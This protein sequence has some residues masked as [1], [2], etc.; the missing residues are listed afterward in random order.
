M[1]DGGAAALPPPAAGSAGVL[2]DGDHAFTAT[3]TAPVEGGAR[4]PASEPPLTATIDSTPGGVGAFVTTDWIA[5]TWDANP[6]SELRY[7][8]Y[9][10]TPEAPEPVRITAAPLGGTRYEDA[11]LPSGTYI[12][13]VRAVNAHG[14]ES[15]FSAPVEAVYDGSPPELLST[16][17]AEGATDVA[18]DA[19]IVLTFSEEIAVPTRNYGD[20]LFLV[21][22]ARARVVA[23]TATWEGV[24]ATITPAQALDHEAVYELCVATRLTDLAGHPLV[25][26]SPSHMQFR[27]APLDAWNGPA[28]PLWVTFDGEG[29]PGYPFPSSVWS[30]GFT[31][32]LDPATVNND[33]VGLESSD[34]AAVPPVLVEL[35]AN[36]LS[37]RIT[38]L[39]PLDP[40]NWWGLRLKAAIRDRAGNPISWWQDPHP[41]DVVYGFFGVYADQTPP[42]VTAAAPGHG[43]EGVRLGRPIRLT[44]WEQID[45]TTVT[46]E[47]VRVLHDDVVLEVTRELDP[48]GRVLTLRPAPAAP[49]AP[50]W[51]VS[52]A[53][54]VAVSSDICDRAGKGLDQEP[55]TYDPQPF[56]LSF[57]TGAATDEGPFVVGYAPARG[58]TQVLP[59]D[60]PKLLFSEPL[61]AASLADGGLEISAA[62]APVA[63]GWTASAERDLL[64]FTPAA[65]LPYGAAVEVAVRPLGGPR[66]DAGL[67][68]NQTAQRAPAAPFVA[69]W[70]VVSEAD[71]GPAVTW[72]EP[73]G[74]WTNNPLPLFRVGVDVVGAD[75]RDCVLVATLDG[76]AIE[77][78]SLPSSAP[79]VV[80]FYLPYYL[81]PGTPRT[82]RV[83]VTDPAGRSR[84]VERTLGLDWEAPVI[85][86]QTPDGAAG[87]ILP[88][89]GLRIEFADPHSGVETVLFS[90]DGA[91]AVPATTLGAGEATYAPAEPWLPGWHTV[92]AEVR[93]RAGNQNFAYWYPL[94]VDGAGPEISAL[95]PA[96]GA[97]L[98]QVLWIAATFWD[99]TQLTPGSGVLE[100]DGVD[101]THAPEA[102]PSDYW[103]YYLPPVLDA[104]PHVVRARVRDVLG[105]E[106]LQEWS[107]VY[108]PT[109]PTATLVTPAPGSTV[110]EVRPTLEIQLSD[111]LVGS[112]IDPN[113]VSVVVSGWENGFTQTG[114]TL[115]VTP[116]ADLPSGDVPIAV[117]FADLAGNPGFATWSIHVDPQGSG[118]LP[119]PDLAIVAPDEGAV[120]RTPEPVL[121]VHFTATVDAVDRASLVVTLDPFGGSPVDLSAEAV[122]TATGV[123]VAI[124]SAHALALGE[125]AVRVDLADTAGRVS[126]AYRAFTVDDRGPVLSIAYP[127][128]GA[129][130]TTARPSLRIDFAANGTPIDRASLRVKLEPLTVGAIDISALA[131]DLP[132]VG[133]AGGGVAIPL[134]EELALA[135][136]SHELSAELTDTAGR[137]SVAFVRFRVDVAEPV[138]QVIAGGL[139]G[140]E[141]NPAG[142][143]RVVLSDPGSGLANATFTAILNK[144]TPE[145]RDVT[146]LALW[147]PQQGEMRL[148]FA[149]AGNA[150]PEGR[151]TLTVTVEDQAGHTAVAAPSFVVDLTP[152]V[153]T[154]VTPVAN[155]VVGSLAPRIEVTYTDE[156]S[157]VIPATARLWINDA[158]LLAGVSADL[159]RIAYQ[160]ID[161]N[162]T[163]CHEGLNTLRATVSDA[164]GHAA[165]LLSE[166]A[167][168]VAFEPLDPDA[169]AGPENPLIRLMAVGG[170][171]QSGLN[172]SAAGQHLL[173]KAADRSGRPL[174]GIPIT[175]QLEGEGVLFPAPGRTTVTDASGVAGIAYAYGNSPSASR[176]SASLPDEPDTPA[177]YFQ[178]DGQ[179]PQVTVVQ[180]F[181][182]PDY[183]GEPD[184]GPLEIR[185]ADLA[186]HPLPGVEVEIPEDTGVVE[187][188]PSR[189]STDA[190]G[191]ARI[192]LLHHHEGNIAI[193]LPYVGEFWHDGQLKSAVVLHMPEP[194][195]SF[196]LSQS[197]IRSGQG[198]VVAPGQTLGPVAVDATELLA[199]SLW[200]VQGLVVS[201]AEGSFFIL[202]APTFRIKNL[203]AFEVPG[204]RLLSVALVYAHT[205]TDLLPGPGIQLPLEDDGYVLDVRRAEAISKPGDPEIYSQMG[206]AQIGYGPA[207]LRW[208]ELGADGKLLPTHS[209]VPGA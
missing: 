179:A 66:D 173:V 167:V 16:V 67:G 96:A 192:V 63:G 158:E 42:R 48:T 112:G 134:P 91:E 130:L 126:T 29:W 40:S 75:I 152:P 193:S 104:G 207:D 74:D 49:A 64:T 189:Q 141:S 26:P 121:D 136:G 77:G 108:D 2:D 119:G 81:E 31:R 68:F 33:T 20:S 88:T 185:V 129:L 76:E 10:A 148:S 135:D 7:H 187:P 35:G 9:R 58:A 182:P 118:V 4:S 161:G 13:R 169:P 106:T 17:P 183:A 138:I 60:L 180:R 90:V 191:V 113:F 24:T 19:P 205:A 53:L 61:A 78:V 133:G 39:E 89:A 171:G 27:T 102:T 6:H 154:L 194:P 144:G 97:I 160:A 30:V 59:G 115:T 107:F 79:G 82:V 85:T 166:F 190:E 25:P 38:P 34:G 146:A 140:V 95:Q 45:A 120:V 197:I 37:I 101:V 127:A 71:L 174:S 83:T 84:W 114:N 72:I 186:G 70:S 172:G 21:D 47:S 139:D 41:S 116:S 204:V 36:D 111:G 22:A 131:Q 175:F 57:V 14:V 12:Y 87:I 165:E 159:Q 157:G 50:A 5:V 156:L 15:A 94:Q 122:D 132:G 110:G 62:G 188:L 52:A 128:E 145:E 55:D 206:L 195:R 51:P 100:V 32:P 3:Q 199:S 209:V 69:Q 43:D 137:T 150:L 124:P 163:P 181:R 143:I 202:N 168:I 99:D 196:G 46:P 86:G 162:P 8:L 11:G 98:S 184:W 153:L 105:Q 208:F 93:D 198:Q 201:V 200:P 109:A 142:T 176:V 44:F 123:T 125:H 147:W 65:A 23:A 73:L 151:H 56:S 80:E 164:A 155:S 149:A 54:R 178:L 28:T 203:H 18:V 1:S 103:I 117:W 177:A 170:Q 92:T